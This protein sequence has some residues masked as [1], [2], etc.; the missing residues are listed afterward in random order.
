MDV[1]GHEQMYARM[2]AGLVQHQHNLLLGTG[3][4]GLGEGTQ[5]RLEDT[6]VETSEARCQM[7]RLG[8]GWTK[9]TR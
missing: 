8:A 6:G 1:V 5:L 9:P 2:P 3:S 4:H 7:V